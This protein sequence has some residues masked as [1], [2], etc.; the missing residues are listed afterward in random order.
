MARALLAALVLLVVLSGAR[1]AHAQ[2]SGGEAPAPPGVVV[3]PPTTGPPTTVAPGV[4]DTPE[5][6][7]KPGFFDLPGR[8]K[9][10]VNDW[11][12]DLVTSALESTLDLLGRTLLSTP[13]VT[14]PGRVRD[15]WGTTAGIANTAMVLLAL[16]GGV[17]VMAH[18]TL[19]TRYGLKDVL[20]RL[21]VAVVAANASLALAGQ[22]VTLANG[23]SRAFLGGELTPEGV[24]HGIAVLT[25]GNVAGG[26]IFVILVG[27][28]VAVLAG[29]LLLM[30]VIRV[31]LVVILVAAAPLALACHALPQTEGLARLW[32]RAFVAVLAVQVGQALVLV[33][34]VRVFFAADG[35]TTL[36][37]SAGGSLVDLLV[38][39]SLLYVLLRIPTWA[40]KAAFS[41]RGGRV[42]HFV[43]YEV[44]H[45]V[46]R[47]T[48]KVASSGAVGQ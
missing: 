42:G 33:A 26:S 8:V 19:Q 41:G 46:A 47:E 5:K 2:S 29:A 4:V 48:A 23:L 22:A 44:V 14:G 35:R 27:L 17:V 20:P 13:L 28:V 15:L 12:R 45:R 24:S 38:V 7:G 1:I 9:K 40:R 11:F 21:V 32:W 30:Y 3:G 6:E 43:R 39:V 10:A 16:V 18:E 31:A 25:I 37:L 34:A 36:G